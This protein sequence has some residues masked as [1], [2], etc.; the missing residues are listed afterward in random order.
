MNLLSTVFDEWLVEVIEQTSPV[1]EFSGLGYF[2]CWRPVRT[3]IYGG[4]EDFGRS[5]MLASSFQH[6][7]PTPKDLRFLSMSG[8]KAC[9]DLQE[10]VAVGCIIFFT[11]SNKV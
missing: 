4:Y 7:G 8:L 5:W 6:A 9:R 11:E 1:Q 2:I 10:E 3:E